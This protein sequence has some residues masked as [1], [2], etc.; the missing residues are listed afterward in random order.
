M[1]YEVGTFTIIDFIHKFTNGNVLP[2]HL[3]YSIMWRKMQS[4]GL[5]NIFKIICM[6]CIFDYFLDVYMMANSLF[7]PFSLAEFAKYSTRTAG[8]VCGTSLMRRLH[9]AQD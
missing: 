9:F 7:P 4:V 1:F 3:G 2:F 8:D 6:T 5:S